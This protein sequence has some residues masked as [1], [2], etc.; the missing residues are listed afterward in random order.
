[1]ADSD[2]SPISGSAGDPKQFEEIYRRHRR[3]IN[4]F[5]SRRVPR[6]IVDDVV[7][8]TF[9]AAF[10]VRGRYDL[11]RPDA[12]P[13]LIGMAMNVIRNTLRREHNANRMRP[14]P[15]PAADPMDDLVEA[16]AANERLVAGVAKHAQPGDLQAL[17]M[18]SRGYSQTEIAAALDIPAATIRSRMARLRERLPNPDATK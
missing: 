18:L 12:K 8:D 7:S 6:D 17:V 9:L 3:S 11:T 14:R 13:W 10:R 1:M 4:A 16:L 2:T 15:P 5:V